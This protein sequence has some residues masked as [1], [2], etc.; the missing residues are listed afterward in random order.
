METET[1]DTMKV[2][3]LRDSLLGIIRALSESDPE[4]L[5]RELLPEDPDIL[6]ETVAAVPSAVNACS[7][8]LTRYLRLLEGLPAEKVAETAKRSLG[9]IDGKAI[10]EAVNAVSR[11]MIHLY[12]AEGGGTA[13]ARTA[14]ARQA[15]DVMDFGKLRVALEHRIQDNLRHRLAL[16]ELMGDEPVALINMFNLVPDYINSVLSLLIQ[17]LEQLTLPPE[18][19]S[20]A[21]FKI[22]EEI[23]WQDVATTLNRGFDLVCSLDRGSRILADGA[24]Q[25]EQVAARVGS[26]I[27]VNLDWRRA[28]EAAGVLAENA[29]VAA[30]SIASGSL[31]SPEAAVEMTRAAVSVANASARTLGSV[32]LMMSELPGDTVVEMAV[33]LEETLDTAAVS[34]AVESALLFAGR[35]HGAGTG[36]LDRVISD[37]CSNVD[38]PGAKVFALM[39]AGHLGTVFTGAPG[40]PEAAAEIVNSI[41]ALYCRSG[42]AG[43]Q[44][45]GVGRFLDALDTEQIAGALG[46]ASVRLSE[47][48][49]RDPRKA[50]S[51]LK[52]LVAPWWK[53]IKS[54]LRS[55]LTE[56][57]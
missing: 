48:A 38:T 24:N 54:Y 51:L 41:A 23:D 45:D 17:V 42:G 14:I 7:R 10:G 9:A 27:G 2:P 53:F 43:L 15:I 35:L 12:R 18:A 31:A 34:E 16:V 13:E 5:S 1:N 52:S 44:G 39:L 36:P 6:L 22:L 56:R 55:L 8:L 57:R 30:S 49:A 32:A 20:F 28:S 25:F 50:T 4:V 3:E 26:D 37:I 29:G 21:L 11:A 47:A 33:T 46:L 40:G 19:M